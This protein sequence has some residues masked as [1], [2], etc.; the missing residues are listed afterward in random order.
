MSVDTRLRALL[1]SAEE[2]PLTSASR[3]ILMSD[4]HRGDGS[5]SDNFMPNRPVYL[6][7]L[8][9][10]YKQGYTYIEL[11]DGDELWENRTMRVIRQ[12]HEET[13]RL[14]SK[15]DKRHR[16]YMLYGNHDIVKS[17][18]KW[19]K[20]FYTDD[21][22]YPLFPNLHIQEA[23]ILRMRSG[24][25]ILLV[26]G[27]QG[28]IINDRLWKVSRF[29]VRYLWRPLELLG[30]HDPTSASVN[31]SKGASVEAQLAHWAQE[32]NQM[33]IAGHT[34]HAVFSQPGQ[35][36]YYNDGSCVGAHAITGLEI[37]DGF[38][39][40]VEW[41]YRIDNAGYVYVGKIP[42]SGPRSLNNC[43]PAPSSRMPFELD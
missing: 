1:S 10:Y 4:C 35:P 30:I 34:H 12:T 7:A 38:I 15:F 43:F 2:L 5:L 22:G 41:G 27:H 25:G 42:L 24:N 39:R 23:L 37:A 13:F 17:K 8:N 20:Q 6:A 14:L 29:L 32:E 9:E 40:L 31:R 21:R 16:L 33:L 19:V 3:Y 36:P 18:E 28:D 26:H 11:G